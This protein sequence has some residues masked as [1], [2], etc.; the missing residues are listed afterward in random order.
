MFNIPQEQVKKKKTMGT[1]DYKVPGRTGPSKEVFKHDYREDVV[2]SFPA[3][4]YI[5]QC[6]W[7]ETFTALPW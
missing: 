1:I 2:P 3:S 7:S 5:V 4:M 6:W